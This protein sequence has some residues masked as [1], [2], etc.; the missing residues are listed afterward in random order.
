VLFVPENDIFSPLNE[1]KK[2]QKGRTEITAGK[3]DIQHV[4][5]TYPTWS[6]YSMLYFSH[7]AG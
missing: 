1:E 7:F 3:Y 2:K 5:K 4:F 6:V